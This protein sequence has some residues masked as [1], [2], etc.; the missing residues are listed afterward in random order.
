MNFIIAVSLLAVS[1]ALACALP[2][3]ILVLRRQSM[4]VDAMSHTV[5]PGIVIGAIISGKTHSPLMIVLA[6]LLGLVV[7]FGSDWLRKTGLLTGDANQGLI[8]PVLFS[9]GVI[10]L[11][12][13]LKNVHISEDTVFTGDINLMA[14]ESERIIVGGF[15]F[16]PQMMWLLLG[17]F[18]LNA[19]FMW[20]ARNVLIATTFD[21]VLARTM[22]MPVQLIDVGLM[23]LVSLTVVVSFHTAG[24]ILVIAFMVIP[25]A[26]AHLFSTTLRTFVVSTLIFAVV[27][28]LGG[29]YVAYMGNLATS[30]TMA[31]VDGL[32]FLAVLLCTMAKPRK[33][34]VGR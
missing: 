2:G 1:T 5:L 13:S 33:A 18:A 4:I 17:V 26:T 19:L 15:D 3:T 8:F 12:T 23:A 29:F 21:P 9:I 28:A 7:V 14:L 30:A 27:G 34:G 10:L 16:G 20:L 24:A 32:M 31:T 11:S 25:A 22:G 6:T